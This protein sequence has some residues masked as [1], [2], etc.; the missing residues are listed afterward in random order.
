MSFGAATAADY[1]TAMSIMETN[2]EHHSLFPVLYAKDKNDKIKYWAGSVM[3]ILTEKNPSSPAGVFKL[4]HG[5]VDGKPQISYRDYIQGK[6]IGK[7]NE[8]TP[9]EQ[10]MLETRRKWLDKKE[11]EGY[12]E[13]NPDVVET[14]APIS[15]SEDAEDTTNSVEVTT[16]PSVYYPML[17]QTYDPSSRV[18]K[19]NTITF[20]CYVQPKIDGLRC[21]TYI[22]SGGGGVGDTG[23]S[24]IHQ[25]RTGSNFQGLGHITNVVCKYL[26]EYPNI[27]LDG[28]LYS[29]EMP[30]EELV[31]LIKKKKITEK[32]L[33]LLKKVKYHIYD[34][35]DKTNLQL[36]FSERFCICDHA[37][38]NFDAV[39]TIK[40]VRTIEVVDL[41]G[42]RNWFAAFV[43][44]GYEGIMLRN[45]SGVYRTNFRS[46]DLQKYKEFMEDEYEIIGFTQG[47]GRDKGS[48]IW[49]CRTGESKEFAVRP[50]G[51]MEQRRAWF[52]N[53]ES[54]IGKKLTVIFQ[55]L[56]DD[57]K[58]RFPV[59]KAIR[60]EY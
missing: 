39:E 12:L 21:L 43:E 27:I 5:Y 16:T 10:C 54:F 47:E 19:K 35:I 22:R 11:K 3:R 9:L 44:E 56:T 28:E 13:T 49:N 42:F 2:M 15:L 41:A 1:H 45:K 59:G 6:N 55:E 60:D 30:F 40:L 33:V 46:H 25:S 7:R 29:D 24:I 4:V 8:T 31:G 37:V 17:A 36:P 38:M 34:C 18:A 58:P 50:R 57:G 48:V 26:S 53:G 23:D 51:T 32:D 14:L 20:P 52:E